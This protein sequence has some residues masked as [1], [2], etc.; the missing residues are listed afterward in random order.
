M[1]HDIFYA[2]RVLE[3]MD[4]PDD[5]FTLG[6]SLPETLSLYWTGSSWRVCYEMDDEVDEDAAEFASESE[7]VDYFLYR[8]GSEWDKQAELEKS[9]GQIFD[10][11]VPTTKDQQVSVLTGDG[12]EKWTLS[13]DPGWDAQL[14]SYT[15]P[16]LKVEATDGR[17]WKSNVSSTF[18]ALTDVRTQLENDDCFLLVTGARINAA[19]TEEEWR[20]CVDSDCLVFEPADWPYSDNVPQRVSMFEHIESSDYATAAEQEVFSRTRTT[21]LRRTAKA[22]ELEQERR[23]TSKR[24]FIFPAILGGAIA[25]FVAAILLWLTM[26]FDEWKILLLSPVI[27]AIIW[28]TEGVGRER[29]RR[30]LRAANIKGTFEPVGGSPALKGQIF[31]R[32]PVCGYFA[33]RD[34]RNAVECPCKNLR[35]PQGSHEYSATTGPKSIALYRRI[36]TTQPSI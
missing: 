26:S 12:V 20:Y 9:I 32:C 19:D 6:R 3:L 14:H 29:R 4:I 30:S 13:W 24:P 15:N 2:F 10:E 31:V 7:A 8:I 28:F 1:L 27:V 22:Q 35:K 18:D 36:A 34:E 5:E 33:L 11:D 16:F 21:I 23:Q 17:I 25:V